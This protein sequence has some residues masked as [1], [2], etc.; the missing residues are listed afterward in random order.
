M[1]TILLGGALIVAAIVFQLRLPDHALAFDEETRDDLWAPAM[2]SAMRARLSPDLLASLGLSEVQITEL[3]CR[4]STCRQVYEYPARLD[5]VLLAH[6]LPPEASPLALVE[7]QIGPP[8]PVN[9]GTW[10]EE[11]TRGGAPFHR[12]GSDFRLDGESHDPA[13]YDQWSRAQLPRTRA[14]F[15]KMR[16]DWAR[17]RR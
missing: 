6:G 11:L 12:L 16:A 3:T 15:V 17:Q 7:E 2:E 13:R 4:A 5:A 14:A 9:L 1:K 10:R 8:A